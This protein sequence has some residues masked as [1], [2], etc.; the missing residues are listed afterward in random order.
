MTRFW[1]IRHGALVEDARNRCY[2]A[3]DFALSETGRAQV[4][5]AADYLA[6]EPIFAVYTSSLSRA[7]ESARIIA[8]PSA[9]PIRIVPDLRE[10]N[11]GDLEGLTYDQIATRNPDIYR[12]WMDAPTEVRFP[13]GESF[14]EMRVRV[15]QAFAAIQAESE[16]RT[17]ALVT[18]GGVIR[19][20]I[21]WALQMPDNCV[22][23][24]AQDYGAINLLTIADG[25]PIVQ[26]LNY[27][28]L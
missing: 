14:R 26:L 5:R 1:L 21:A 20:L 8:E 12:R 6:S 24:L 25:F 2:G 11:F 16:G 9:A 18:H 10:M 13:N 28:F 19:I 3:L 22:F 15:L 7:V 17:V 23:R 27:R 4:A